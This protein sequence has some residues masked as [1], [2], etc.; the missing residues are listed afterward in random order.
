MLGN[1][2]IPIIAV[3]ETLWS[4]SM[5]INIKIRA[6]EVNRHVVARGM[7]VALGSGFDL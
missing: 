2:L 3:R 1:G 6:S 4:L 5:I 7:E